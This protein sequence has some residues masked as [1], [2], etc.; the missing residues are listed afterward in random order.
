M[1]GATDALIGPEVVCLGETMALVAPPVGERLSTAVTAVLAVAGA[2]STV[3]QYLSD[4]GHSAAWVS[5]LGADP[6]G[7]RVIDDLTASGVQTAWVERDDEA[8]TGIYLKDR[9][10]TGTR[11]Y[12]YRTGSAA[13]CMTPRLIDRID[14]STARIA[15]V[16]GITSAISETAA[17][18]MNRFLERAAGAGVTTSFDVNH[19]PDLWPV[20]VAGPALLATAQRCDLVFV[21]R[22]EA[23]RLWGTATAEDVREL[24][25]VDVTL[26]VKDAEVGATHFDADGECFEPARAVDVVEPVGAGDAFAAGYISGLL[27]GWSPR[28]RLELGHATAGLALSVV[29]DH[30]DATSL[31]PEVI[32]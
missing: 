6:L 17:A 8:G 21:G 29:G 23:E 9:T 4:L 31:R 15:H 19:R 7:D 20:E 14:F 25:G 18:T 26:V 22:D 2:E 5:R 13:S 16:S 11:V 32:L 12:Y 3:A 10:A 28:R 27:R 24:I 30:A 1:N